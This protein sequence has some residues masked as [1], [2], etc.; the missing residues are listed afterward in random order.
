MV[1]GKVIGREVTMIKKDK[2]LEVCDVC[3][4]TGEYWSTFVSTKYDAMEELIECNNCNGKG[5]KK[6]SKEYIR[7]KIKLINRQIEYLE[8]IIFKEIPV[9]H[10]YYYLLSFPCNNCHGRGKI[11]N[12]ITDNKRQKQFCLYCDG[13]GKKMP[14]MK[15]IFNYILEEIYELK[16]NKKRYIKCLRDREYLKAEYNFFVEKEVDQHKWICILCKHILTDVCNH[17]INSYNLKENS[18]FDPINNRAKNWYNKEGYKYEIGEVE[19]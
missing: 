6:L 1:I 10:Y 15:D 12:R 9:P 5:Y 7:Y 17:C 13:I 19:I 2:I 16:A 3:M 8:K 4:G 18:K 11:I 14:N